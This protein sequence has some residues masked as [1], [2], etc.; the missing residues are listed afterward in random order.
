MPEGLPTTA[1]A[2]FNLMNNEFD[3]TRAE[4]KLANSWL[5]MPPGELEKIIIGTP[6]IVRNTLA[7]CDKDKLVTA[8]ERIWAGCQECIEDGDT[9]LAIELGQA[10]VYGLRWRWDREQEHK[11]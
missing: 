2:T 9:D 10:L 3:E 1:F 5:E 6:F 8:V 7:Y 4:E 11:A